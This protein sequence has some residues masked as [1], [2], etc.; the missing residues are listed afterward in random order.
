MLQAVHSPKPSE[1]VQTC[2]FN[3]R[4]R[5]PGESVSM[6]V[7]ELRSLAEFCNYGAVLDDMVRDRLVCGINNASIQHRL[8]SEPDLTFEKAHTLALGFDT[9]AR[10]VQTLQKICRIC[11]EYCG[12]F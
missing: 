5:N 4:Y 1:I 12:E 3:S 8:L 10:N 2:K 6:F 9:A 11:C 7:S